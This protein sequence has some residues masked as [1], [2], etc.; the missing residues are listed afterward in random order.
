MLLA[1]RLP[2]KFPRL[3]TFF[4]LVHLY[5]M[6]DRGRRGSTAETSRVLQKCRPNLDNEQSLV[7]AT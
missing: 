6:V 3:V 5:T 1:V 7:A 2:K 4:E